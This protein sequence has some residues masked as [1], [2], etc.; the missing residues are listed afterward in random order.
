MV[1]T[2]VYHLGAS[3]NLS[4]PYSILTREFF[5]SRPLEYGSFGLDDELH[6]QLPAGE[7][8]EVAVVDIDVGEHLVASNSTKRP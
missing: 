2:E 6:S 8:P 5:V 3:A 7:A 1:E 4:I